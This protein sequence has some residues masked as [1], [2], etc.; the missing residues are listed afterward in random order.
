LSARLAKSFPLMLAGGLR[1]E[2]VGQAIE[3]V[4]PAH[5]DVSSGVEIDG[6]KSPERI[7][8]FVTNARS[9]FDRYSSSSS[10]TTTQV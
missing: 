4:R 1:P 8:A 5:V 3:Q 6:E 9:A 10:D 7:R 2:N